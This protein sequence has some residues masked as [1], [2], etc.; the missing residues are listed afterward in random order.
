MP[1]AIKLLS[2]EFAG[3]ERVLATLFAEARIAMQ[4]SHKHIVRLHNIVESRGVYYLVME[5][6][7]G[8]TL[9][10]LLKES[11]AM[12]AD[13]VLKVVDVCEDA[14][15][16][17]HR[18]HVYHRDLKPDNLMLSSD[19]V[20]K[21]IDFGLACLLGRTADSDQIC[22]TPYYISPEEIRGDEIDHRSD[23][24]SLS[25]MIHELLV[26]ELP[27]HKDGFV[28]PMEDFV[29]VA[30]PEIP[31]AVAKVLMTSFESDPSKRWQTVHEFAH[32]FRT[33]HG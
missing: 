31:E 33:A 8:C 2:A 32:A 9:R 27:C 12:P 16:Y 29:P 13:S 26:G 10:E 3:D 11:G 28:P 23:I 18:H 17:A 14:L 21:I 30:S 19:G 24:Y 5:Y 20:L 6:I 1:V 7:D 25:I 15:G 4:L 22:G